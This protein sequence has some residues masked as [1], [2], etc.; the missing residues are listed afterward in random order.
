MRGRSVVFAL[1][2]LYFGRLALS[3][4]EAM[5]DEKRKKKE[6]RSEK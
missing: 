5:K 3:T 4:V 6:E 1:G 2:G